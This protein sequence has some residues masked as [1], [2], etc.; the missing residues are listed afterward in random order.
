MRSSRTR[1]VLA[2]MSEP[3]TRSQQSPFQLRLPMFTHVTK[4]FFCTAPCV[5]HVWLHAFH[6]HQHVLI[7]VSS[8]YHLLTFMTDLCSKPCRRASVCAKG[9]KANECRRIC[10][11]LVLRRSSLMWHQ[12]NG[13]QH[14][15]RST[16]SPWNCWELER[17]AKWSYITI[18]FISCVTTART[19]AVDSSRPADHRD[20][21]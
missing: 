3:G 7:K 9:M 20:H 11:A 16:R 21:V 18:A 10:S 15:V 4:P 1:C 19:H 12:N 2:D 17:F 6:D 5:Q 8:N 14:A 13:T